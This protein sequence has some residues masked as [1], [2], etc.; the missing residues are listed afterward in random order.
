MTANPLS[1]L[2]FRINQSLFDNPKHDKKWLGN[3]QGMAQALWLA[4]LTTTDSGQQ[5]RLKVVVTQDQNQLNQLET[6]LRFCG[7][8]AHVFPDWETLVYDELSPHQDI[9]AE[10]I[11]LLTQMPTNGILLI[12]V[13]TLAQR[14]APISWLIG[15]HFDLSVGD[16]F[17]IEQQRE[18]L[19]NAGY[20]AV[21]NVFEP[22]EFAVRGSVIDLFA[23]GQPFP[24]RI[25]LFDDEID[26]IRFFNAKTQRSLTNDD[27]K[28]LEINDPHL[29][30]QF[31]IY[32]KKY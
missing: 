24:V 8:D 1:N 20:H 16:K 30:E 11:R 15:Q 29:Y 22:S 7:V 17:D 9:V 31:K 10:R 27:I 3:L 19:V 13:Q 4:S 23:V 14:V 21:D 32:L 2:T 28:E 18:R 25:D 5:D 26:N 12:V 6:E